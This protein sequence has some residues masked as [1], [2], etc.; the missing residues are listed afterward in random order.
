[1]GYL[2]FAIIKQISWVQDWIS[3]SLQKSPL[4]NSKDILS[5]PWTWQRV[6]TTI[7]FF[8]FVTPHTLQSTRNPYIQTT[9]EAKIMSPWAETLILW[10]ISFG[11]PVAAKEV[12]EECV[13]RAVKSSSLSAIISGRERE[14]AQAWLVHSARRWEPYNWKS[15]WDEST[16]LWIL[17]ECILFGICILP[18]SF[19]Y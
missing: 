2:R 18:L 7:S 8:S 17:T 13:A 16:P 15:L 4:C 9:L 10:I 11:L 1:M 14:T 3:S 19:W 5:F 6:Y 12:G